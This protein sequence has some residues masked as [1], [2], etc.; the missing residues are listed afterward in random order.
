MASEMEM[1]CEKHGVMCC[2]RC[3][4]GCTEGSKDFADHD[5]CMPAS[6]FDKCPLHVDVARFY[7]NLTHQDVKRIINKSIDEFFESPPR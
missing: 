4:K 3:C 5:G 1:K 6:L 2:E 7:E